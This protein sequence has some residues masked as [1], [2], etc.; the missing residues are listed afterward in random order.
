MNRYFRKAAWVL[1]AAVVL[2]PLYELADY[3]EVWQ[4]DGDLMLAAL[5]FLIGGLALVTGNLAWVLDSLLLRVR[6][7]EPQLPRL[8]IAINTPLSSTHGI[9]VALC[10]LRI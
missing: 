4:H 1:L 3:S 8:R 5:I 7:H 10:D 2:L 6:F 9:R